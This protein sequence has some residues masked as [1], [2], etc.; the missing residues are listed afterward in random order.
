LQGWI[1]GGFSFFALLSFPYSPFQ[2]ISF[3]I[4]GRRDRIV[5][6]IGFGI[7]DF[8]FRMSDVGCKPRRPLELGLCWLMCKDLRGFDQGTARLAKRLGFLPFRV[9][10]AAGVSYG[11]ITSGR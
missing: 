2:F 10:R 9:E 7:W 3:M 11:R 6:D 5:T 1:C 4:N 8:G